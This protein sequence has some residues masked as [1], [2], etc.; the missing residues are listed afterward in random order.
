MGFLRGQ[1]RQH[2]D[3]NGTALRV[4]PQD[5]AH[6]P[7]AK[8][9]KQDV[10]EH[11]VRCMGLSGLQ[12]LR[13][14]VG[15]DSPIAFLLKVV[16]DHFRHVLFIFN[17]KNSF[18]HRGFLNLRSEDTQLSAVVLEAYYDSVKSRL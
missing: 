10:Q 5:S 7:T 11:Q 18:L 1:G 3:G 17:D 8:I 12:S 4:V 14:A 13:S 6:L 15:D 16:A 2:K 9:R